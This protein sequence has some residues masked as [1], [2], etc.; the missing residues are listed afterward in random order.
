LGGAAKF[1]NDVTED[2]IEGQI[3]GVVGQS[4]SARALFI[5]IADTCTSVLVEAKA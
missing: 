3:A 5:E 4:L 1:R 2:V